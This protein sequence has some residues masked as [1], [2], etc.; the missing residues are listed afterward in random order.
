[1]GMYTEI[2]VNVD[3]A[4]DT[5]TSVMESIQAVVDGVP[6]K[7]DPVRWQMLGHCAAYLPNTFCA[8]LND[9]EFAGKSL[10]VKGSIKN[11]DNEIEQFFDLIRPWSETEF[12][13]YMRAEEDDEPELIF[14]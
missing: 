7:D 6:N 1:M 5:P 12:M 10:L 2:Y 13:G 9:S 14:K 3:L 11:K 8:I 4:K